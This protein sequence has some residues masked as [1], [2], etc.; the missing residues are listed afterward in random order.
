MRRIMRRKS[1]IITLHEV[2]IMKVKYESPESNI[3]FLE[4]EFLTMS[5]DNNA[6]FLDSEDPPVND[7]WGQYY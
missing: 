3:I 6:P 1:L 2:N 7:G 4:N 5:G